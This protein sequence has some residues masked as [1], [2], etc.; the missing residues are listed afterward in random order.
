MVNNMDLSIIN[1][2]IEELENSETSL[3][4][5][6]NLSA[7]Y[8]VK[9]HILGNKMYDNVVKELNDVLPSYLQYVEMKRRYQLKEITDEALISYLNRVCKEIK[10]FMQTLYSGTDTQ[11]ER[12][13]LHGLIIQLKEMY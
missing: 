12:D 11:K 3:S 9:S 6:R 10:E 7:L 1:D 4:N 8:N 13:I 2:L 5:I